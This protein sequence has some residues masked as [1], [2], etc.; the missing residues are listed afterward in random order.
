M[1]VFGEG[2]ASHWSIRFTIMCLRCAELRCSTRIS[3]S[4]RSAFSLIVPLRL[5]PVYVFATDKMLLCVVFQFFCFLGILFVSF[6]SHLYILFSVCRLA[7][8]WRNP[9]TFYCIICIDIECLS[10][11]TRSTMEI[12]NVAA[13]C[14][15]IFWHYKSLVEVGRWRAIVQNPIVQCALLFCIMEYFLGAHHL[16]LR[17]TPRSRPNSSWCLLRRCT[18]CS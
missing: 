3:C 5:S 8:R 14:T 15:K 18:T 4:Y 2:M 12:G 16:V 10:G 1:P 6:P 11:L 9:P 13:N 17:W 7:P